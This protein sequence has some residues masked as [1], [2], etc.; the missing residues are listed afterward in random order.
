MTDQGTAAVNGTIAVAGAVV[1]AVAIPELLKYSTGQA[2]IAGAPL[3]A[4]GV[5]LMF[6]AMAGFVY[7][8]KN[9]Q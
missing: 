9:S 2:I 5:A 3:P 1:L 4:L 6:L 8:A 7:L